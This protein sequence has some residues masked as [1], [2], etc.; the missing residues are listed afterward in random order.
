MSEVKGP[1]SVEYRC[2]DCKRYDR[3]RMF[4]RKDQRNVHPL[5]SCANFEM[6]LADHYVESPWERWKRQ[7]EMKAAAEKSKS[8]M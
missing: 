2:R 8:G 7:A 3:E 1:Q 4:C 5:S 6:D